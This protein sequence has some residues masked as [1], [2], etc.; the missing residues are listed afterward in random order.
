M[1]GNFVGSV[2]LAYLAFLGNTLAGGGASL[3]VAAA[4]TSL[5]FAAA[6]V[7]GIMCNWLVCMAVYLASFAKDAVG[8][9]VPI[10]FIISS[11]VAMGLEHSVANM[12]ISRSA[13]ST[14][15]RCRGPLS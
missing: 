2:A 4:K 13:F 11:F 12:F 8:K 9:M 14:A 3:G 1:G 15:P 6:F 5:P 10:W 7:R